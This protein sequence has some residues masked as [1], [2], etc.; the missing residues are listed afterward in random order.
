[1]ICVVLLPMDTAKSLD[2]VNVEVLAVAALAHV[3]SNEFT[4]A[5][6]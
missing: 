1:M 4:H 6:G 5:G 2:S 3:T